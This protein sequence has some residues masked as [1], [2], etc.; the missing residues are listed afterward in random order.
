ML[1]RSYL[2]GKG[3]VNRKILK[4]FSC[5]GTFVIYKVASS[6]KREEK[7]EGNPIFSRGSTRMFLFLI[8]V[9]LCV[10]FPESKENVVAQ[11]EQCP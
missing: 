1:I 6:R 11:A 3:K 7:A 8:L 9:L 2:M 4:I 10:L 5:I